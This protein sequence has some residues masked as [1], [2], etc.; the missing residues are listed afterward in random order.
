[1]LDG[2]LDNALELRPEQHSTDTA[3]WTDIVFALF[4]LL[5]MTFAPRLRDLGD[6]KLY[7]LAE[8]TGPAN[9]GPLFTAKVDLDLVAR[10]WDGLARIAAS[11]NQGWVTASLLVAK[12]QAQSRQSTAT[13]ALVE[14]GRAVRTLFLLRYLPDPAYRREISRQLNKG[15]SFHALRR[16][17][18]IGQLG[19]IRRADPDAQA[20]QA[21]ALN[22]V[23]AAVTCWNT[24]YIAE[25]VEQL[26]REAWEITDEQ[27]AHVSPTASRHINPYGEYRFDLARQPGLRPLRSPTP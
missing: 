26:R 1:M 25:V 17:I 6:I 7:R 5:G 2:I 3:G 24:V 12:L 16:R 18:F 27:L 15:E 9:A 14:H 19:Q 21:N 20:D 10:H 8:T 13:K 23:T 11:L 22:L 4:D